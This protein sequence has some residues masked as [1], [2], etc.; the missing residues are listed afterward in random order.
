MSR[1]QNSF[2]AQTGKDNT[3]MRMKIITYFVNDEKSNAKTG[4]LKF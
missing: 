1:G 2:F 4:G 3:R